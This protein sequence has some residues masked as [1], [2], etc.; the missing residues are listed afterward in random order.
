MALA[1]FPLMVRRQDYTPWL[2][3]IETYSQDDQKL[4]FVDL[5]KND[6]FFLLVYGMDRYFADTDWFLI[7][8]ASSGGPGQSFGFMGARTRQVLNNYSC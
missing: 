1:D 2:D 7:G 3:M 4:A 6:L 8:V 5:C